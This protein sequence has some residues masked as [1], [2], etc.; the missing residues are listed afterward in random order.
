M[1]RKYVVF[2][3]ASL[4]FLSVVLFAQDDGTT[5]EQ[6]N[7][8][9]I[10]MQ[11]AVDQLS[12]GM[13]IDEAKQ[14]LGEPTHVIGSV[15]EKDVRLRYLFA[16]GER[17]WLRFNGEQLFAVIDENDFDLLSTY[18]TAKVMD[19]SIFIDN[20]EVLTYTPIL[21]IDDNIYF[22]IAEVSEI[23]G[24]K[25]IW[26]QEKQRL[27]I[28]KAEEQPDNI[29][30]PP[31]TRATKNAGIVEVRL[32]VGKLSVGM[33]Y[34][35]VKQLIGEPTRVIGSGRFIP[36]YLFTNEESFTLSLGKGNKLEFVTNKYD[37][38]LLSETTEYTAKTEDFPILVDDKEVK[39]SNPVV[40]IDTNRY[41]TFKDLAKTYVPI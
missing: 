10:Q 34:D 7:E 36:L 29:T 21:T 25:I 2:M 9:T 12:K 32:A 19:F 41:A 15:E 18:Y 35:E 30:I 26:N 22:S 5:I 3:L 28:S 39:I 40:T 13:T 20:E 16:D 17:L 11:K 1:L 38:D 37:F 23:I 27:E 14:I 33:T 8:G 24:I 4:A 6:K 31:I